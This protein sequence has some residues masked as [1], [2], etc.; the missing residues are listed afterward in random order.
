LI[1]VYTGLS[2]RTAKAFRSHGERSTGLH[3]FAGVCTF[4]FTFCT[5]FA[6]QIIVTY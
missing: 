1:A 6:Q 3:A 4:Q 5:V 2:I